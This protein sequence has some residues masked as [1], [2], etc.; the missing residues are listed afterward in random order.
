MEAADRFEDVPSFTEACASYD[1]GFFAVHTLFAV[2]NDGNG[3]Y[4]LKDV[5]R[6]GEA[7]TPDIVQTDDPDPVTEE[8]RAWFIPAEMPKSETAQYTVFDARYMEI[9]QE[10]KTYPG[11]IPYGSFSWKETLSGVDPE[12][13]AYQTEGFVNTEA[14][15]DFDPVQRAKTEV[16]VRYDLVLVFCDEEAGVWQVKLFGSEKEGGEE[17]VYLDR[18]GIALLIAYGECYTQVFLPEYGHVPSHPIY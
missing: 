9:Q 5:C 13:P 14:V 18:D 3:R 15:L 16:T 12:A 2:Y 10:R 11:M 17:T 4:G 7:L 8:S 1:K 6:E